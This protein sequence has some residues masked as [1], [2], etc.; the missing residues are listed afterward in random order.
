MEPKLWLKSDP[1][2]LQDSEGWY[3]PCVKG[4]TNMGFM[5][6]AQPIAS[7]SHHTMGCNV[8]SGHVEM[9]TRRVIN[10]GLF[11][12]WRSSGLTSK[13]IFGAVSFGKNL[14]LVF[15]HG[16]SGKDRHTNQAMPVFGEV[17]LGV[18]A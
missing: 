16:K 9:S 4:F 11:S 13:A 3:Q 2:S 7:P 15:I 6:D 14:E 12:L 18:D 17:S 5:R 8:Y 1:P 10:E